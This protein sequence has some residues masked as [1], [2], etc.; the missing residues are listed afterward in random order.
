MW[1]RIGLQLLNCGVPVDFL[2][3]CQASIASAILDVYRV[4][5]NEEGSQVSNSFTRQPNHA[6]FPISKI[7]LGFGMGHTDTDSMRRGGSR[8][9]GASETPSQLYPTNHEDDGSTSRL[10]GLVKLETIASVVKQLDTSGIVHEV[11]NAKF[12]EILPTK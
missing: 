2:R 9:D 6:A 12:A 4:E 7:S 11:P 10:V 5:Q 3:R 1:D 8:L